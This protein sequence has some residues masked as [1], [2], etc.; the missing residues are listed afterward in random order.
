MGK[1]KKL[2][3]ENNS[4]KNITPTLVFIFGG[5]GDLNNR[6]LTPALF[7]LF[8][9]GFLDANFKIFGIG[10][11]KFDDDKFR[12][13]LLEGI[14]S[15]SRRPYEKTGPWEQFQEH[16][17]YLQMDAG[18]GDKKDFALIE[19]KIKETEKEWGAPPN[20]LFY[21]SVKP[22]LFPII[23]KGI[24]T[25]SNTQHN[26][27]CRIVIE[28]PFG[29][30]LESAVELNQLLMELCDEDQIDRIDHFLGKETVQNILAL[31]FANALFEPI[32][33]NKYIDHVQITAAETVG[34]EERGEYF[35]T[36]G[37]L[38][39]MIQNHILQ[40]LCM[41]AMEAPVSFDANEIR[42]K[43]VD[44]LKAIRIYSKEEVRENAVRG[45]YNAGWIMGKEV[46]AYRDESNVNPNSNTETF[47]AVKFMIDNWRWNN[48]PF[49][50][51]SGKYMHEK[52]TSI[53]IQFKEAPKYSFP[54]EAAETWRSNR[55]IIT[56]QPENNI[57]LLFQ[58]KRPG[59]T[60][61]LNPVEMVFNYDDTFKEPQPEAY[62]T[63]LLDAICG[64]STQFMRNDQV[65]AAWKVVMPILE[66][67]QN[68]ISVDFPNYSP[69]SWGPE[70]ADA[71]IARDGRSWINAS[72][73]KSVKS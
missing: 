63:L 28:K 7:N 12:N 59:Q 16:L 37:A 65:E 43:K 53:I 6:K 18:T 46:K 42:N 54:D 39:D 73:Q 10:R 20:V 66:S 56:I 30:D 44:V 25:I 8:A 36:S 21:L 31:R 27:N 17:F 41:V 23:A 48:V 32:W 61:S 33:N 60:M 22:Q 11:T 38:R 68:R 3:M 35:E 40:V 9:D 70:E 57:R 51:R 69:G 71:M 55:L 47:A 5:S 58:A 15:F 1:L 14:K 67:W 24:S 50:V 34:V 64:N 2:I 13:H 26:K 52:L 29:H 72:H 49:Y 62:E 45:Q 19:K 4:Q